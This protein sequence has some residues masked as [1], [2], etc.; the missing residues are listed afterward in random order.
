VSSER[1]S[2]H[3]VLFLSFQRIVECL[4]AHGAVSL[5]SLSIIRTDGCI[6]P[7]GY[8]GAR[9]EIHETEQDVED[10]KECNTQCDNGGKCIKGV[11]DHGALKF[12]M[13]QIGHIVNETVN[14][15]FEHCLCPTGFAGVNCEH[16]M[17]TCE[18]SAHFC[19][20][21][22]TCVTAPSGELG[23]DCSNTNAV[24]AFCQ[25]KADDGTGEV[26][27]TSLGFPS[28]AFCSN[29]GVCD[30]QKDPSGE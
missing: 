11:K 2:S 16:V 26:C 10:Y 19:F 17:E 13:N 18:D 20:N 23:C 22:G 3:V 5:V 1:V 24:G 29:D 25:H 15:N 6:C 12:H 14:E 28:G 7:Q 30:L 27:P 8:S 21:G 9:C 4:S